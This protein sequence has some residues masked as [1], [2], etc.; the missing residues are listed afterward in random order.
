M[1]QI[2]IRFP[3]MDCIHN[4]F[5]WLFI[6]FNTGS[7]ISVDFS[8]AHKVVGIP[9]RLGWHLSEPTGGLDPV[10]SVLFPHLLISSWRLGL[11]SAFHLPLPP[12]V[13]TAP[14]VFKAILIRQERKR[15]TMA[16]WV[17]ALQMFRH[18][19]ASLEVREG[20]NYTHGSNRRSS[21][22]ISFS[23]I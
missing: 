20:V 10:Q 4:T 5:M 15:R 18:P 3:I 17:D 9:P 8:F 1:R 16:A 22:R 12:P 23:Q 2:D 7:G 21:C 11:V 13:T 19:A 6:F 14:V